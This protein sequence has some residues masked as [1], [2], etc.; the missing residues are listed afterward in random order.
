M[1]Q[2]RSLAASLIVALLPLVTATAASGQIMSE[3]LPGLPRFAEIRADLDAAGVSIEPPALVALYAEFVG[4]WCAEQSEI[5]VVLAKAAGTQFDVIPSVEETERAV[6]A[7]R[8]AR[9][10][11]EGRLDRLAT[12]LA[13]ALPEEDRAPIETLRGW[14]R[15]RAARPGDGLWVFAR[16]DDV[17]D[18]VRRHPLP[19]EGRDAVLAALAANASERRE[20]YRRFDRAVGDAT[21]A[22]AR[23]AAEEGESGSTLDYGGEGGRRSEFL[24]RYA[25]AGQPDPAALATVFD[26]QLAA[27]D[28]VAPHLPGAARRAVFD[29][30][31]RQHMGDQMRGGALR[32]PSLGPRVYPLQSPAE[33]G[34]L[35]IA[36]KGLPEEARDGVRRGVAAWLEEDDAAARA[37]FASRSEIMRG[38]VFPDSF[39]LPWEIQ[40]ERGAIARRHMTALAEI[41]GAA[42]LL[43]GSAERIERDGSRLADADRE[44]MGPL[45][46]G[47]R[48]SASTQTASRRMRSLLPAMARPEDRWSPERTVVAAIA[49]RVP[50]DERDAVTAILDEFLRSRADAW[51]RLVEP[52]CLAAE[53]AD[54]ASREGTPEERRAAFAESSAQRRAAFAAVAAL[55]RELIQSI[56][57]AVAG[58]HAA[59]LSAWYASQRF[60]EGLSGMDYD[61][62]HGAG[63][64]L[65]RVGGALVDLAALASSSTLPVAAQVALERE[66]L[67]EWPRLA[68]VAS[69]T[70]AMRI[71]T[72]ALWR[73][74][75][76][77]DGDDRSGFERLEA[78]TL[79][80]R[81]AADAWRAEED[82]LLPRLQAIAGA[83]AGDS[84]P[85]LATAL[86]E[87]RY[88]SAC[89]GF[90][91]VR[92]IRAALETTPDFPRRSALLASLAALE[93][94]LEDLADRAIA[95]TI[96]R[97]T[98]ADL[99]D[100]DRWRIDGGRAWRRMDLT[101]GS[102]QLSEAANWLV[103]TGVPTELLAA[104]P[105]LESAARA[106]AR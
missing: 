99:S 53:A 19:P 4:A 105:L 65:E 62:A 64:D 7:V 13:E 106:A 9:S 31:V 86:R 52:A 82:L 74:V 88:P 1:H 6:A 78:A 37:Y 68:E 3:R 25:R 77:A 23:M 47:L 90:V 39:Q 66:L 80:L 72:D 93:A 16:A 96:P 84:A 5:R 57:A 91:R 97:R 24:T 104:S 98:I 34:Q 50:S 35:L 75:Y 94:R 42:W 28:A 83:A 45:A 67:A 95:L 40:R 100:D 58:D 51:Q 44:V 48:S 76:A 49:A 30:I 60:R 87:A 38:G 12:Q 26:T 2:I 61:P 32:L 59:L 69:T 18:L 43:D 21:I 63:M 11:H 102:G 41:S 70:L 27:F 29:E 79:A 71:E 73:Q 89:Y 33:V 103:A 101:L 14:W 17:G 92:E 46:F 10:A 54:V 36:W 55:D 15:I 85:I 81:R 56:E 20:A 8:R 22:A